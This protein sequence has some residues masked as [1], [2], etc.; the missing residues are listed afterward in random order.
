MSQVPINR[1]LAEL[2][3]LRRVSGAN[4]DKFH[5]RRFGSYK[6][7]VVDML[8]RVETVKITDAIAALPR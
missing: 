8:R 6:G 2:D 3:R 4:R 5:V 7:H 1:Y